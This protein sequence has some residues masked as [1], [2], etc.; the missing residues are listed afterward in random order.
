[1][2]RCKMDRPER[3]D[4]LRIFTRHLL[5]DEDYENLTREEW[6]SV[7]LL[8][9]HQWTKGGTLPDD[10][11]KLAGLARCSQEE[12]DSLT[13]KWPKLAPVEGQPGRVGIP[14]VVKE[15]DL[16]MGFYDAQA[17]RSILGVSARLSK[18][19]PKDNPRVTH[20]SIQGLPAGSPNQDQDQ[21]QD[22]E[23]PPTV[24]LPK[25]QKQNKKDSL[26]GDIPKELL[27]AVG[28]IVSR[29][30]QQDRDGRAIRIVRGE[31]LTRIQAIQ[32][33]HPS[34]SFEILSQC[35]KDYLDSAPKNI[36][37]PQ[38][39]FGKPEH[40]GPNGANWY[41]WAKAIYVRR[42]LAEKGGES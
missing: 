30:P 21:D 22:Q 37:A 12:L 41:P 2:T 42:Q 7:F 33:D 35:W 8:I 26:G 34:A 3:A 9:L 25:K 20:G 40:Q 13:A 11:E 28:E 5:M 19:K 23:V 4:Y 18:G 14:Y 29:C 10:R 24:P 36:K 6:G 31:I 39:F 32:V 15:W 1:M 27:D 16:V 17:Q 38:Y